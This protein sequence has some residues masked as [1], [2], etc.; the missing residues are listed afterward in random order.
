LDS[1]V[2]DLRFVLAP[3][4]APKAREF[5]AQMTTPAES[6]ARTAD[7]LE[8]AAHLGRIGFAS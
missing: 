4:C 7:L 5:A 3:E 2:A 6:A 1:L 8:E